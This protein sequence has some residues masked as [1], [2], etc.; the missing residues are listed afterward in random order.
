MGTSNILELQE[1]G[2]KST[3]SAI[4]EI[5]DNAIQSK[6]TKV[7]LIIIKNTTVSKDEIEEILILDDGCGMDEE[8]FERALQMSSGTR[9]KATSGLGKY[10]QGLPNSSISQTKRVEIYTKQEQKI[11]FNYIDLQEIYDSGEATLPDIEKVDKVNIPLFE[12]I[13]INLGKSGTVVRWV[14][15]NRVNPKTAK[16]LS[17][18]LELVIGRIYRNFI[19]GYTDVDGNKYKSKINIIVYDY[20]GKGYAKNDFVS[21][22]DIKAFDP[23]FLMSDTQMIGSNPTSILHG[24]EAIKSF[25]VI[26]N[27]EETETIVKLRVSYCPRKERDKYGRNAGSTPFGEKYLNRNSVGNSS[28]YKNISIVRAGREIDSGGF[29][30]ISDVSDPRH[31]WWSAEVI[32]DPTIDSIIG[33]DNK[34]QQAS[35]IEFIDSDEY[36]REDVHEISVWISKYLSSNIKEAIN[37]IKK[38]DASI[39][40]PSTTATKL[41]KL[42]P[43]GESEP[44][45]EIKTNSDFKEDEV[46][47]SFFDWIKSRYSDLNDAEILEMVEYALKIRD[48]HIF[49]KSDLGDTILYDYKVFGNKVLIEINYRHSFYD[50]FMKKFEEEGDLLSERAIR[51]LIGSMVNADIQVQTVDPILISDRKRIRNTIFLTLEDYINDLYKIG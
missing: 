17:T 27:G 25:K 13:G 33:I 38:E 10:G 48:N 34:K 2:Y 32:V 6:S 5:I 43:G 23:M 20:N 28:A 18:H 11:L 9:N 14:K 51:L 31:R 15:P 7:D 4:S 3:V 1:N 42:P 16:T 47:K 29:G 50:K 24:E 46:K 41:I 19:Q 8:V 45:T 40:M 39:G 21:K 30:F 22:I 49:I 35:K 12:K 37:E 36:D 44:G 26:Y